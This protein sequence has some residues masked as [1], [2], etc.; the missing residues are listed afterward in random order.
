MAIEIER[1]FLV[2]DNSWR[3]NYAKKVKLRQ[4][5]L[6]ISKDCTVRVRVSDTEGWISVK[7]QSVNIS[8]SEFEYPIPRADAEKMLAEFAAG[9][10]IEKIRYFINYQG[11]EWVVDE[12]SGHNRGL[13]LTEI[14]LSSED[15]AYQKPAWA[16]KEVS[17]DHR[18]SNSGLSQHPYLNWGKL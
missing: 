1:K 17:G 13:I 16:G 11:S 18:Y 2:Q 9:N 4:G 10:L 5:Y 8:R 14:E 15:A 3:D 6:M 7:G 12:F